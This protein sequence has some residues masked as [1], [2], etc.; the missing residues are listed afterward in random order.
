MDDSAPLGGA[1]L[2]QRATGGA[3]LLTARAALILVLGVGANIALARLLSPREFGI[4]ALGTAFIV[5]G[6]ALAE[7]GLGAALIRRE[8]EPSRGELAAVNAL[9]LLVAGGIALAVT[10]AAAPFGRDGLVVAAMVA[11]LPIVVLRAPSV[12]VLERRLRFREIATVDVAEAVS[13]Y[14]AALTMVA[15]GLGLWGVALAA[16]LRA[17]V[18]T[19]VMARIGPVGL[20]RP[21]WSWAEVGGLVG[22]GVRL[23]SVGLASLLRE[24]ALNAAVAVLA[25]IATLGVWNL[26]WRVLQVPYYVFAAVGRV[27]YPMIARTLEAGEDVRRLLDRA[28]A[29]LAAANGA[30]V[31]AIAGFAPAVPAL[32]GPEW[33]DVPAAL[34][35]ASV[36]LAV[37]GPNWV[38]MSSYLFATGEPGT[39]LRVM[40]LHTAVWFAITLPLVEE[41]GAAMIGIGWAAA[42]VVGAVQ[43][44]R[45]VAERTGA[46]TGAGAV[47][48]VAT[49]AAIAAGWSIGSS[50]EPSVLRGILGAAAGELVLLGGLALLR[51]SALRDASGLVVSAIRSA[52]VR[53]VPRS[54]SA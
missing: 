12:I 16:I 40:L 14:A 53:P 22:F 52:G 54:G 9:Q 51:P 38:V 1:E 49:L 47:V 13:F 7:G 19:A 3:A 18:G 5:L 21:R 45:R 6:N 48:A 37:G 34:L 32:V 50:G 27:T 41:V 35:W 4:V 24:Q 39:V 10:A 30:V 20:V 17:L 2:R 23:Q 33:G 42:A 8:D 44:W 43:L 28:L 15:L 29:T 26:A 31:V 36:A 46:R 11:G 25:G